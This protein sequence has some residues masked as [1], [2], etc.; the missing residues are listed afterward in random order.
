VDYKYSES[1]ESLL[2]EKTKKMK[3]WIQGMKKRKKLEAENFKRR[4]VSEQKKRLE[5]SSVKDLQHYF[6]TMND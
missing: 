6:R 3:N 1:R 5:I 2:D 4:V